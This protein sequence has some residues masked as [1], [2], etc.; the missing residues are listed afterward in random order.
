VFVVVD[1]EYVPEKK[2]E[3]MSD[4]DVADV[5]GRQALLICSKDFFPTP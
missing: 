1:V 2:L 3:A 5:V 4:N